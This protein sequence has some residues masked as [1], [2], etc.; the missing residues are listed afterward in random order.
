MYINLLHLPLFNFA[1][2][3]FPS[4]LPFLA[5]Q[6]FVSFTFIA[7]FPN[8]HIT[9]VLFSSLC[10]SRFCSSRYNICFPLFTRSIYCTLFFLGCFDFAYGCI[11]LFVYSVT[12]FLVVIN[13]C[14]YFGPLQFCGV[15]LFSFFFLFFPLFSIL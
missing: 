3:V 4:F 8:W 15:F 9:L 5:C 7:L 14:L 6:H 2:I 13:L 1:Y 12:L 11:C 10:F